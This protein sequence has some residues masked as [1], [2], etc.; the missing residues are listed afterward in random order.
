MFARLLA[1]PFML[2]VLTALYLTWEVH[3]SYS[4]YIFPPVIILAII[5]VI[6]PQLNWWWYTR[7]PQDLSPALRAILEKAPGIYHRM[8]EKEKLHFRQR[9]GLFRMGSEF[10]PQAMES[11]PADAELAVAAAAVTLLHTKKELVFR[12]HEHVILYNHLFPSPQFPEIFHASEV[13]D[14]DGVVMF[15]VPHLIKGFLEPGLYFP[16][17]LYEYARVYMRTFPGEKFPMVTE[18]DW[19]K[20]ESISGFFRAGIEEWVNTPDLS[21]PAVAVSLFFTNPGKFEEVWPEA[22]ERLT[23]VFPIPEMVEK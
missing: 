21:L 5:F 6:S 23:S 20:L 2:A 16:L 19:P 18:E 11:S 22:F 4:F 10:M 7:H 13:F 1:M 3:R 14:E 15:S 8:S 9:V 12:T 17:G